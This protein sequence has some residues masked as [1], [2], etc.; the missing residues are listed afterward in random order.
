MPVLNAD[1]RGQKPMRRFRSPQGPA[2]R[3]GKFSAAAL[4]QAPCGKEMK[5][6]R[7]RAFATVP[8]QQTPSEA[9]HRLLLAD[10]RRTNRRLSALLSAFLSV[11][12]YGAVKLFESP[13]RAG[14]LPMESRIRITE[15]TPIAAADR[16][17]LRCLGFVA[18]Q[19]ACV[20]SKSRRHAVV[21]I[22]PVMALGASIGFVRDFHPDR[23]SRNAL[24]RHRVAM[25][26]GKSDGSGCRL[27]R[28]YGKM[29]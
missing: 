8:P 28:L 18:G 13:G 17:R 7:N 26:A 10:P 2:L 25:V 11:S 4:W 9:P 29:P 14:G 20:C 5:G 3:A 22:L 12:K 19:T 15:Q 16:R 27:V 6:V 1:L 21:P 23:A 24:K